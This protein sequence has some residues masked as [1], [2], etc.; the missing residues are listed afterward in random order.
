MRL[1]TSYPLI[2]VAEDDPDDCEILKEAFRDVIQETRFRFF[3][4]GQKLLEHLRTLDQ[5]TF[6]AFILLDLNMPVMNGFE[7]LGVIKSDPLLRVI[8]VLVLTTSSST[9]DI[10]KS[11]Q[12]GTNSYFTKPRSFEGFTE[13]ARAIE[14][15]WLDSARLPVRG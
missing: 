8:P 1:S 5:R 9:G 12:L 7:A 14:T 10:W 11:Y 2:F 6:P 3:E 4:N 15:Y 13:L